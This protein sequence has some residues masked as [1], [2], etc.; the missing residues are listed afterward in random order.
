MNYCLQLP[1]GV[2][3]DSSLTININATV[4]KRYRRLILLLSCRC[5]GKKTNTGFL[6]ALKNRIKAPSFSMR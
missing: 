1:K 2:A 5:L 3:E 4:R 6:G